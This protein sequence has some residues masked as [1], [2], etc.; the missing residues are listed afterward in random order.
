[1]SSYAATKAAENIRF[2]LGTIDAFSK[3]WPADKHTAMAAA[4]DKHLL[5]N[6]GHLATSNDWFFS[7]MTGET[8]ICPEAWHKLFGMGSKPQA[9]PALY[10][11]LGELM[12][13]LTATVERFA[14][15]L[16]KRTDAELARPPVGE[17]HGMAK[18]RL[19][20]AHRVAWHM[21]WHLG[22]IA[23]CR[24]GL[25]LPPVLS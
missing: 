25:G 12:A 22:Q 21:G 5:W 11:P 23:N 3:N 17:A 2:A 19:D 14:T 24:A 15:E 20:A 13:K 8:G 16:A 7:L 10:P 18:D 4:H 6:I 1:M 9:N